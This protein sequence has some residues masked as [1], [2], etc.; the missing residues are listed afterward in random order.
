M[1]S[2]SKR[3]L[4][5]ILKI[6]K[7]VFLI[8]LLSVL[9]FALFVYLLFF[10]DVISFRGADFDKKIWSE[11]PNINQGID[12]IRGEMYTDLKNNYLKKG[13][14]ITEVK[15]LL[16]NT[17]YSKYSNYTNCLDYELGM[18]SRLRVDYD[19]MLVCFDDKD[20][21]DYVTHIQH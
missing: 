10:T 16:G 9:L 12:C 6:I 1:K 8:G 4:Q 15:D 17:E 21:V 18:C 7:L 14:S 3:F 20:K 13:I 11:A 5:V 19:S 2:K